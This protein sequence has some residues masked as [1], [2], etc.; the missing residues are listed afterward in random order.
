MNYRGIQRFYSKIIYLELIDNT[1]RDY[2]K[3]LNEKTKEMMSGNISYEEYDL[4]W[5][6]KSLI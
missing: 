3:V 6:K 5:N 2:S 4:I 1:I